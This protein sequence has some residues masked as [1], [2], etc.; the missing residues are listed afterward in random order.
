MIIKIM[1]IRPKIAIVGAG[2]LSH[3]K[4]LID[5]LLTVSAFAEGD[6]VLMGNNIPRLEIVGAYAKK[7]ADLMRPG[8]RVIITDSLSLAL[9]GANVVVS[10]FN[11]GGYEAFDRDY[12]VARDYGLDVCIGDTAGPLGAFRALRNG[13]VMLNIAEDM[14]SAC[15]D[16]LLIN[17]VNPMAP[18]VSIAAS[19]GISC[20]GI[21]GGIE[22]TR[23]YVA[24][25]LGIPGD[26]LRTVFAGVNH[27]C[28]LL[29]IEGPSGDFYPHFRE[30][31]KN[32]ELRGDEA[33]RFE[34]LQQFGY[35]VSESSGH[36]SDFFPYFRRN[37]EL[38]GRY[39]SG[40]GYSGASGAYH[41]LLTFLQKRIG[42]A[43][44][45]EG[46]QPTAI[47]SSDYGPSIIEAWM[48]NGHCGI[49]GNVMNGDSERP[50]AMPGLPASACVEIPIEIQGRKLV[51]PSA[52]VLP[53]HLAALCMP[54]VL[55][56][57]LMAKA[58]LDKDP[59]TLFAAIAQDPLTSA[60]LDLP[61]MRALTRSLFTANAEWLPPELAKPL[62]AT[63][64]AGIRP[65]RPRKPRGSPELD[66]V[67]NYERRQRKKKGRTQNR[68]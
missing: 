16:A 66:L 68:D 17:Y 28:W 57:T 54:L 60:I 65:A 25:V 13:T 50:A 63:L 31:M 19:A 61:D 41:R 67:K 4:R 9:D 49:Y 33:I 45:L 64:N 22:A 56:H 38:R 10:I 52:P 53:A 12:A 34:I 15:P 3:G 23:D 47:R 43:D 18:M 42:N 58:F 39:C 59:E 29:G 26:E 30:L 55:Q 20:I 21:C 37:A 14:K 32:P 48:G 27:L 51:I 44:Y 36:V 11:V 24:E 62:R 40:S 5:D 6:L 8:I 1:G 46:Q 35:F 7:A 2:S